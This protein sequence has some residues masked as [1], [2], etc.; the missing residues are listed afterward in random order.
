MQAASKVAT[1]PERLADGNLS[2]V[3]SV[4]GGVFEYRFD[5]G[6]AYRT[7]F[8]R[9]GDRLVILLAGGQKQRRQ[10][11]IRVARLNWRD[12]RKRK[13][14]PARRMALTKDFPETIR[15]RAQRQPKFR[16]PLLREAIELMRNGDKRTSR[17]GI[18]PPETCSA[19]SL[20]SRPGRA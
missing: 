4:G 16:Q 20:T 1:A 2:N 7:N 11:D 8:G 15:K 18:L 9:D 12:C 14:Q 13:D 6:H 19:L 17:A 10:G 3:K 5:Y